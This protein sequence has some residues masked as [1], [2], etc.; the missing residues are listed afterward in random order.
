MVDDATDFWNLPHDVSD[1]EIVVTDGVMWILEVYHDG[2]YHFI[3]ENWP[4]SGVLRDVG[5]LLISLSGQN[6]E[7]DD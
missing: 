5:V 4:Q 7:D 1:P 6:I 2:R 3:N